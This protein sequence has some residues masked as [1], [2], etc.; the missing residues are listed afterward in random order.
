MTV[1]ARRLLVEE[2]GIPGFIAHPDTPGRHPGIMIIHH[3]NGVTSELKIYAAELARLGFTVIAPSLFD[4]LGI[5]ANNHIGQGIDLQK[6]FTDPDFLT[7]IKLG[8]QHLAARDNVDPEHCGLIAYCMGG[9][10]SI[11]FAYDTPAVKAMA[12][13]YPS[14]RDE[15]VTDMRPRHAFNLAKELKCASMVMYGGQDYISTP[16]VQKRLWE[17]FTANGA[18]LEWHYYAHG[19]HGFASPDTVGYQPDLARKN[20]PLVVEFLQQHLQGK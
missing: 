1:S 16:P 8:W 3:A 12:L 18:P 15:P 2:D 9:R 17:S 5:V 7:V 20:W 6:K 13:Y 4:M 11:P 14:I 10:L 19:N